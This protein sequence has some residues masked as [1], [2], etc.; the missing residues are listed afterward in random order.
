MRLCLSH[1]QIGAERD[2]D[3]PLPGM[4][5]ARGVM[6]CG[7]GKPVQCGTTE[8]NVSEMGWLGVSEVGWLG[9]IA[10]PVSAGSWDG[11]L[12]TCSILNSKY[13]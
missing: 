9:V 11:Q 2:R 8:E 1:C 13:R 3:V 5:R 4:P 6:T 12:S 7:L 10:V